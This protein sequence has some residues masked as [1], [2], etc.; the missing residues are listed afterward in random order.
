MMPVIAVP[1]NTSGHREED[2][3]NSERSW[4]LCSVVSKS[5]KADA[6]KAKKPVAKAATS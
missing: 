3:T 4:W 5:K 2:D 6:N 1:V